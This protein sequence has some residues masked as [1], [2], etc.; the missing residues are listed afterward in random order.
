MRALN[1][2]SLRATVLS[3]KRSPPIARPDQPTCQ[4]NSQPV[5][6]PPGSACS[7]TRSVTWPTRVFGVPFLRQ[8][9][10][11]NNHLVTPFVQR[12]SFMTLDANFYVS[13]P[14]GCT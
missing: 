7:N 8:L 14:R 4:K 9:D 3:S 11:I 10:L 1:D 2:S 13:G 12:T 5:F 6:R